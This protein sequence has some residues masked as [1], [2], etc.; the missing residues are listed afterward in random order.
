[1]DSIN[2]WRK[3]ATNQA[4]AEMRIITAHGGLGH[5]S[6]IGLNVA[7]STPGKKLPLGLFGSKKVTALD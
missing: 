7:Q 6:A 3:N 1:M 4:I 2:F 5:G